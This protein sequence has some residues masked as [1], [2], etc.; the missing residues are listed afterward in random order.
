MIHVI[1]IVGL[2]VVIFWCGAQYA[3]NA[4]MK[5]MMKDLV[6]IK[7]MMRWLKVWT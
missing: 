3:I 2:V 6:E 7:D 5:N 4:I 1:G